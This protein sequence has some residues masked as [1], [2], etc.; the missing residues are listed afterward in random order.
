MVQGSV[1]LYCRSYSQVSFSELDK[2]LYSTL[3]LSTQGN[4]KQ[5]SGGRGGGGGGG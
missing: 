4:Q 2:I 3:S 5:N 1:G